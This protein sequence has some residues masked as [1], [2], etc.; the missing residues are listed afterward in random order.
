MAC[1]NRIQR[2]FVE[3]T[4]LGIPVI[5]FEESLHGLVQTGAT[6]YPQAIGLAATFDADLMAEVATAMAREARARGIRQVLSPVVNLATDVRWGR[7][8]ETYGEDPL[9]SGVMGAAF[10]GAFERHG[11]VATPKH[12]VA[13]VG[14]GGRDS[15][16]IALGE[17]E[18]RENDLVPFVACFAAGARSVM[19]AY[20]SL[21]GR[22]CSA[23]A[24]LNQR[25]LKDE[26]GFGGFVI[27][28]A[29]AVGGANVLHFTA[30][31]YGDAT[32]QALAGGLDVIFQTSFD[33]RD[34]FFPPFADGRIAPAVMDT[35]V[36]RVLRVKFELGLF[37]QPYVDA[38]RRLSAAD[39]AAHRDLARRAAQ[40][41]MVLLENRDR[42]LPLAPDLH[43]IAVLGP[44]ADDVRL[45]G[46]SGPGNQPVSILDGIRQAVG[47]ATQVRH[48][49]GCSRLLPDWATV[50]TT[51]LSCET[52]GEV[53]AGLR[54]E[55]FDNVRLAGAPVLTRVDP[56]V[57]FQW[58][59]AS[60]DPERL[61]VDHY[62]VRW[63]GRL[64]RPTSE[65]FRL[66]LEGTDGYRL[67]LDDTLVLDSWPKTTAGR[68][69]VTVPRRPRRPGPAPG[70]SRDRGQRPPAADVGPR[71]G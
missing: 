27:S 71:P 54:G 47:P 42:T 33:H 21:D 22:P 41:A 31:D 48:A 16:P 8:E 28:D 60:P 4:R 18:L 40:E 69:W 10:V 23:S 61:P 1:A 43:T 51:A 2:H 32:A 15:Y 67:W 65:P 3:S 35:A 63:T 36:A 57:Q 13:N 29:G 14:A 66:G 45:G 7:T 55:Y 56:R 62:A 46:Y 34:L 38:D 37:D 30:T 25:W 9:L 12:L 49:L 44:D 64:E 52:G 11:V 20:N 58:T 17:R 24:W 70:V 5:L 26:L 68:R 53:A 6:A 39:M 19:T 59:L 50:P